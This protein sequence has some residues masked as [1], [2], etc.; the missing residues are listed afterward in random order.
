MS[1]NS[2]RIIFPLPQAPGI[3]WLFLLLACCGWIDAARASDAR[4]EQQIEPGISY[5]NDRFPEKPLSIH[6]IKVDRTRPD[7]QFVTAKAKD[8]VLGLATLTEQIRSLPPGLG[9]PKVAINGDFYKTERERYPGDPRGLL[10]TSGELVSAPVDRACLWFDT[11]SQP[12]MTNVTSQF[13][14]TWPDGKTAPIG[15]NEDPGPSQIVLFTPRLGPTTRTSNRVDIL[16]ERNAEDGWLPFRIGQDYLARIREI[17]YGG[18]ASLT[19]N[20][21][22]LCVTTQVMARIPEIKSG[23]LIKLS[24]HT[25]PELKGANTAIGGGPVLV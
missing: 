24:T 18:N 3:R 25:T 14:V 22:V 13:S 17:K 19:T 6:V 21:M 16:L 7:F 10:I 12:H 15:L 1:N 5:W 23:A 20:V 9:T 8:S 4:P 11:A 2:S